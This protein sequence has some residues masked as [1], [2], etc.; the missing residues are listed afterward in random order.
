MTSIRVQKVSDL[1]KREIASIFSRGIFKDPRIELV[2]ITDVIASPDLK[3]MKIYFSVLE[4][5]K[6]IIKNTS[7]I[8]NKSKAFFKR[9]LA[10]NLYLKYI[11]ELL[12]IH[13]NSCL[14]GQKMEKIIKDLNIKK[15]LQSCSKEEL[16][17]YFKHRDDFLI[18]SHIDPD[19]DAIG[20][21]IALHIGLKKIGKKSDLYCCSKIPATFSFLLD[22]TNT[23]FNIELKPE[24]KYDVAV[25][26][27][28]NQIERAGE[29][30]SIQKPYKQLS[31]IDHHLNDTGTNYDIAYSKNDSA[32]TG[33]LI[34][35]L[36][37]ELNI[38]ITKEIAEALFVAIV[39]DTGCFRYESTSE[40]VFL[41]VAKLMS[42]GVNPW[43]IT[44]N[45]YES[46]PL[47]RIEFLAL[48]LKTLEYN[49]QYKYA[50]ISITQEMFKSVGVTNEQADIY[51]GFINF[52][53][54][55]KDVDIAI[56]FKELSKDKTKISL[57]SKGQ[58]DVSTPGV[59]FGGGGHKNA[60]GC[61]ISSPLKQAQNQLLEYLEAYLDRE[62]TTFN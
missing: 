3:H 54:S 14:Y 20:S 18:V 44:Q 34:Y 13:D 4:E 59:Y 2:T 38:E 31:I 47:K 41:T 23:S 37:T 61:V 58:V 27:D 50:Y 40:Q 56:Q 30:F 35:D 49:P 9:I 1:V 29:E 6:Q 48:T 55:I 22:R 32:A 42:A 12:F 36:L 33:M 21:A 25:L 5:N 45:L 39:T 62:R 16:A 28:M 51:D 19:G 52:P 57:R 53:R 24:T 43:D 46:H 60:A 8:L 15:P 11:P 10:K 7:N 26:I 17:N